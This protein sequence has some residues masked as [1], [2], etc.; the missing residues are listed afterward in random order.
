[1]FHARLAVCWSLCFPPALGVWIRACIVIVLAWTST[2]N[3]SFFTC[4][5][6][7]SLLIFLPPTISICTFLHPAP[8][9]FTPPT[10]FDISVP[11]APSSKLKP[12]T[13]R[14]SRASKPTRPN[15]RLAPQPRSSYWRNAPR[16]RVCVCVW[17]CASRWYGHSARR[18]ANVS[19]INCCTH[20]FI[21]AAENKNPIV[22]SC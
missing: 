4:H 12:H 6:C 21:P 13:R 11:T 2:H 3:M 5:V 15:T 16:V 7:L 17:V 10:L 8:T 1:M 19:I 14:W 22:G 18:M 9:F 20:Q